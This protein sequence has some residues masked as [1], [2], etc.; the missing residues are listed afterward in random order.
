MTGRDEIRHHLTGPVA[1][2]PT[3]F[4][5]DGAIDYAGMGNLMDF[6]I[7]AGTRT[8]LLTHGDSLYSIL[9]DDEIA[10]VTRKVVEHAAGR[11][12]V[13]AATGIWW[14]GKTV[15]F[16]GYCR[17]VGA[18]LLMV[19]PPDWA[20]SCTLRTFVDY[21]AA[22]G[23]HIP[24]MLITNVF[25]P[26]GAGAGLEILEALLDEVP[27]LVAIKDDL[28]GEFARKMGLL[29]HERV[30]IVSGGQKQNHLDAL[31][32]ECDGYL[33]TF[34][35]FQPAPT[36]QYW[37]AIQA[38]DLSAA[39]EVVRKYDVPYFDFTSALPGGFDA[40]LHGAMELFGIA[41]R[42]RRPPYHSLTDEEMTRLAGFFRD[43]SLL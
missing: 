19:L 36:H 33:S 38:G 25:G 40:G 21:F 42:W 9:T 41:G 17:E 26:R 39:V 22:V 37:S 15:E 12:M 34:I 7:G 11:A 43:L 23:E 4:Q 20:A 13:V 14:T 3:L 24:L 2:M 16:A 8:I 35:K 29:A 31:P 30:A 10:E 27:A 1:S 6:V 28:C 32:Y 18:D 5:A